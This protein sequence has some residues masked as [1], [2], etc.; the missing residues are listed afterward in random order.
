MRPRLL[1]LFLAIGAC[2]LL[3]ALPYPV[4]AADAPAPA[5]SPEAPAPRETLRKAIEPYVDVFSREPDGKSRAVNFRLRLAE[6]TNQPPSLQGSVL[7]FRCQPPDKAYFQFAAVGM[8]VTVGRQGQSVW[9]SPASKLRPL[10]E[11]ATQKPPTKEEKL[12][13]S[14]LRL[15]LPKALFWL[16]FRFAGLRD[17][18]NETVDG[19]AYRKV[20]IDPPDDKPAKDKWVRFWV[21]ADTDQLARVEWRNPDY[22][23]TLL[24]EEGALSPSLPDEAFQPT[25][26]QRA[27][28]M[29]VPSTQFHQLM[30]F[31]GKE[32]EKRAKAQVERQKAAGTARPPGT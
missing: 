8:I 14:N 31:L 26:A 32:E 28:A 12:P 22:H 21:R 17:G 9:V 29:E 3:L 2:W 19:V 15:K 1:P 25:A 4:P 16:A 20:E 30:D 7:A 27:D 6:S 11:K 23:G 10:L 18:G 5:A 13:L 24:V